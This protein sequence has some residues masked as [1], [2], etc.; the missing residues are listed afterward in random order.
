MQGH[1][2]EKLSVVLLSMTYKKN[3]IQWRS[4]TADVQLHRELQRLGEQRDEIVHQ[5][6]PV[7]AD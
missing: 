2:S 4:K 6:G 3:S 7:H 1:G 5:K